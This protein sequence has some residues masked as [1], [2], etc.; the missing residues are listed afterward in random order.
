MPCSLCGPLK[1]LNLISNGDGLDYVG[2]ISRSEDGHSAFLLLW[3]LISLS[4]DTTVFV[5]SHN[6]A[7]FHRM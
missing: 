1:M 6:E 3:K 2:R 5:T 7:R 4:R